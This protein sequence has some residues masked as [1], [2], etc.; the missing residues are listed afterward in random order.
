VC[1][2]VGAVCTC[3]ARGH[4][5][6]AADVATWRHLS[7]ALSYSTSICVLLACW[8]WLPWQQTRAASVRAVHL[9]FEQRCAARLGRAADAPAAAP[10]ARI[11][12]IDGPKEARSEVRGAVAR[13]QC[14]ALVFRAG[15]LLVVSRC[16]SP[17][18]RGWPRG[19]LTATWTAWVRCVVV[20]RA[21]SGLRRRSGSSVSS[22]VC[23]R[24]LHGRLHPCLRIERACAS[25]VLL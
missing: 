3:V 13:A 12:C 25:N 4:A 9:D 6:P 22:S 5:S 8:R 17:S 23:L 16:L 10:A 21:C 24:G 7:A 15:H 11:H 2:A 14:S 1:A 20:P 18:A 19:L